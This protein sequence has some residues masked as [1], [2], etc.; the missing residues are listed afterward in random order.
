[1]PSHKSS[2]RFLSFRLS[3][4]SSVHV[5]LPHVC[6]MFYW[7]CDFITLVFA[8]E[9]KLWIHSVHT[10]LYPPFNLFVQIFC[11]AL[12]SETPPDCVFSLMWEQVSHLYKA[13]GK[14][15]ALYSLCWF[16]S[17]L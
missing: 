3:N 16:C 10:F 15:M 13:R 7:Y 17:G 4:Q 8:K 11:S 1:M 9:C 6:N 12:C 2:E 14:I 5:H